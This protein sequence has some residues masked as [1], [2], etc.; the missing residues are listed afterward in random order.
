[1]PST[2]TLINS[3]TLTTSTTS[4]TFSA[5][6]GTFTDLLIRI[7]ARSN[8]SDVLG[9]LLHQVNSLTSGYTDTYIYGNGANALSARN[10]ATNLSFDGYIVGATATSN[11]FGSTEIYIPS[12]TASQNKPM[13]SF[14]V[15]EN[16]TTGSDLGAHALL[17]SNT[18]AISSLTFSSLGDSFV[19]GS[20]FYLYGIKKS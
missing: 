16:N 10:G 1:M 7:S 19:S 9:Y 15:R 6:P 13:S 20:S 8:R 14:S 4:V 3:N 18:A 2:Y 17:L 12:Y 11:T 5:I